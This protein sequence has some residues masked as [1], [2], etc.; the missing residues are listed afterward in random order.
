MNGLGLNKLISTLTGR[1]TTMV[2]NLSFLT[3]LV[4]VNSVP[5]DVSA[6]DLRDRQREACERDALRLC[7]DYVPDERRIEACMNSRR[8]ELSKPCRV[9][10][11][12]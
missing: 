5:A 12:N 11:T 4:L 8:G 6:Q 10:F 3:A 1:I 7:A 2:K 9:F